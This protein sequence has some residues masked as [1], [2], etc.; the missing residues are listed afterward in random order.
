MPIRLTADRSIENANCPQA[1]YNQLRAT[2]G[3]SDLYGTVTIDLPADARLQCE[4]C[5][6]PRYD[7]FDEYQAANNLLWP[8]R[9]TW[10]S[11]GTG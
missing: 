9:L 8:E 1:T 7:N 6:S 4:A 3:W 10:R 11:A 2:C 5:I